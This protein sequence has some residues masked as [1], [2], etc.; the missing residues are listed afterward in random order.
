MYL[1]ISL[2]LVLFLLI[3]LFIKQ[4]SKL[5]ELNE[6]IQKLELIL[7]NNQKS[8][9]VMTIFWHLFSINIFHLRRHLPRAPLG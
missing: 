2:L 1:I 3:V 5:F 7:I 8:L 4:K 9:D 6:Q